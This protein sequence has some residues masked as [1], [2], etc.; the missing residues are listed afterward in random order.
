MTNEARS[1]VPLDDFARDVGAFSR[2]GA[3]VQRGT[4]RL[5]RFV[6]SGAGAFG[7]PSAW[8]FLVRLHACR[9]G[10]RFTRLTN[11]VCVCPASKGRSVWAGNSFLF[12]EGD[13]QCL[14]VYARL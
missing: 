4:K 12:F 10:L 9:A 14:N 6:A 2:H 3:G 1:L 8:L 5:R 13:R 7:A 11:V